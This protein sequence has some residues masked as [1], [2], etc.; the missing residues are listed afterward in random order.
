M[1]D[2]THFIDDPPQL[3]AKS[4]LSAFSSAVVAPVSNKD[5]FGF[6][7]PIKDLKKKRL[8]E[9]LRSKQI[10]NR[11]DNEILGYTLINLT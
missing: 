7:L 6:C 10:S 1:S 3:S 2:L 9:P 8:N 11:C 5:N 4:L